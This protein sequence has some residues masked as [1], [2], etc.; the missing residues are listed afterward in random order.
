MALL[1]RAQTQVTSGQLTGTPA[2]GE[3]YNT[4]GITLKA[5]FSFTAAA[6][7]ILR[8]YVPLQSVIPGVPLKARPGA[9]QNYIVTYTPRIAGFTTSGQLMADT[10]TSRSLMVGIQYFDGLGRPLQTVQV[11]GSPTQR[12]VVQPVAYDEFGRETLKYQPYAVQPSAASDGSYKATAIA[13]QLSFYAA[14][15][16]TAWNAPGVMGTTKPFAQTVF[17]PSPLNRIMEQGAPG[18]PWQP[19]AGATTGHTVKTEYGTNAV[20]GDYSVRLYTAVA[21]T[22]A[23][24]EYERSLAN[25]NHPTSKTPY[26][27]AGELYLTVMKD[28]NYVEADGLA[29]QVHEYKDK[30]GHVVLK[31]TFNRKVVNG[32]TTIEK[33]STYYVYDDLGNL[34]FVLPPGANADNGQPT[35]TLQDAY[36]YRYRYDDRNRLIEKKVPGQGWTYMVYNKLDQVVMTQDANQRS[37]SP[38]QMTYTKYDALGRAVMTGLWIDDLA[39]SRASGVTIREQLQTIAN[40]QTKLWEDRDSTNADGQNSGYTKNAIPKGSFGQL[41]TVNYYDDYAFPGNTFGEASTTQSANVKSL[42]TGTKVNVLGTTKMLL[43]VNYYDEEGRVVQSKSENNLLGTDQ[44]DNTYSFTDEL[45]SSKRTHVANGTTTTIAMNYSYDHMGRKVET[46]ESINDA[47]PTSLSKLTYNEVGQLKDKALGDGL[48]TL[49]YGYNE[50]GWMRTMTMSGNLFS[51]DL[52]YNTPDAAANAQWN[53][54]IAQMNYLT[55]KVSSPGTKTFAY[56]YDKL[57][58]LTNAVSTGNALDEAISYDGMGNITKLIRGGAGQGTLD[59]TYSGNQ[60]TTVTGYSARSYQYDLNGNATSDGMGKSITY[61]MLNLPGE[62][63]QGTT[64]LATYTYD[65]AG[66]KLQNKSN[67]ENSSAPTTWDYVGGIVYKGGQIAF[68]QTEE[69]RARPSGGVYLYEYNLND[70]LGNTRVSIDKDPTVTSSTTPRIIQEDEYY[71][72]GLR[73]PTGGYDLSNNNRYLYNGK[74]V[75]TDLANQYD[76]GARFYDPV[77]GRW[78]SVDPLAEKERRWSPYVYGNNN[79]IRFIDPDGMQT[80]GCCGVPMGG[81]IDKKTTHY[82]SQK[83]V[84]FEKALVNGAIGFVGAVTQWIDGQ[85]SHRAFD[86]DPKVRAEAKADNVRLSKEIATDLAVSY[87][88]GKIFGAVG[89]LFRG[90]GPLIAEKLT[91]NALAEEIPLTKKAFGHTFETHGE[92]MTHQLTRRASGSNMAQGQFL[93]NQAAAGFINENLGATKN[94]AVS[95]PMPEGFPARVINPDGTYSTPTHIRLV[96]SGNGVKTAYP[97]IKQ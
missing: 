6:G 31:R 10:T 69:G 22:V 34:S 49:S 36:C 25:P 12:D 8:V 76:Y 84:G 85:N 86:K 42:L 65:A 38:Q 46:T 2:A 79:P 73:K 7:K 72:F 27:A 35:Q 1:S 39:S 64:Q 55:K 62:V 4:T 30:E 60:L 44:T 11:K 37:K 21:S 5:P 80:Q 95:I 43:T 90:E 32:T 47:A 24:K 54:N 40:N 77:I 29:G 75:Q 97:E 57:N 50:R 70:H 28:E 3:Y 23:G 81:L 83:V 59:Y 91:G 48:Q 13:D 56:T 88:G 71:S 93:D 19:V 89:N 78:T 26:Y 20:T 96:P 61:N 9:D 58:R 14:P 67:T 63:K 17:E 53:G 87:V 92:G 18:E 82:L 16:G 52:R 33:L 68:I 66:Q 94:G 41:L 51:L 74:E 45:L 15:T